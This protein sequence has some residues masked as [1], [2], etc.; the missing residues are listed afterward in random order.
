V[1]KLP[2]LITVVHGGE[3]IPVELK[4]HNNLTYSDILE[5]ID[6]FSGDIYDFS[7][8]V[9]QYLD[10]EIARPYIDLNREVDDRP[11]ENKDGVIKTETVFQKPVYKQ[12]KFLNNVLIDQILQKYYYPFFRT[13]KDMECSPDIIVG[14]DCHTM[15]S[16]SPPISNDPGE[17][18]PL[19][20]LS[21]KGDRDGKSES[22]RA[23]TTCSPELIR[24]LREHFLKVFDCPPDQVRINDPF[25]GGYIIHSRRQSSV[26]WVQIELNRKLYLNSRQPL[27]KNN[28]KIK[29]VKK[30]IFKVFEDFVRN[31]Q[32]K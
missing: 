29:E 8:E 20:C 2:L 14:F 17:K 4:K 13:L 7:E 10:T 28:E 32:N 21:N 22:E 26:S 31:W 18:R 30:L 23:K 9:Q 11:P 19:V 3:Q 16:Y 27:K 5:D 15:L 12:G 25:Q 24:Q 6:T 1:K